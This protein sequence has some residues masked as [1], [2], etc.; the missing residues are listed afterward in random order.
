MKSIAMFDGDMT[1][2]D[3][4]GR[5]R[6]VNV[7]ARI[8]YT[9]QPYVPATRLDPAEGGFD[10]VHTVTLVKVTCNETG[11][12]VPWLADPAAVVEKVTERWE[13]QRAD[14][15]SEVL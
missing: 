15:W 12:E 1:V 4:R 8:T 14:A 11:A 9:P 6:D 7:V 5:E 3:N 13:Q 2:K 10:E